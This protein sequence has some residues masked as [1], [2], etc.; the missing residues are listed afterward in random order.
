MLSHQETMKE[1]LGSSAEKLLYGYGNETDVTIKPNVT[2]WRK[3]DITT[4]FNAAKN[5]ASDSKKLYGFKSSELTTT[6][7]Q[8][9]QWGAVAYL[10]QSEYGNMQKISDGESGI[11]NNSYNEGFTKASTNSHKMDNYSANLTG[12]AGARRDNYTSYYSKL[13]EGSKKDNGD[14]IEITYTNVN[15]SDT[16]GNNSTNKYYRYY[17]DNGQ[18]ASTTRNIYG[19]YDMSGGAW[20]YTANYLKSVTGNTYVSDFLK[21]ESKYQTAYDGTGISSSI[22]DR[23][24]NYEANKEKY[25]D[26]IWETSNGCDGQDSWNSDYSNFPYADSPFFLRGGYYSSGPAAGSFYF[27]ISYGSGSNYISF[28]VV[29]F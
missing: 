24:I 25:G 9:S 3:S 29:L 15:T 14:S 21:I 28:R 12:T 26:A 22:E 2:S 5:M 8:N 1:L 4:L 13:V 20:E 11:W 6:M 17:T 23:T 19:I 7:M 18:K 27:N 10:A 16:I